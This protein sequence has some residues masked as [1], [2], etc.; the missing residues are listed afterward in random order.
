MRTQLRSRKA[1]F[2]LPEVVVGSVISTIVLT[3]AL[4]LFI[5]CAGAWARGENL[6]DGENDTRQAVRV[7]SDELRQAMLVT[8]DAD[9]R[10]ITYRHPNK[11]V[12][13]NFSVPVVWDGVSRRIY[14]NGT[15]LILR[16]NGGIERV[17]ARNVLTVDPFM[18]STTTVQRKMRNTSQG[19]EV[20]P[21]YRI[22]TPSSAGLINEVIVQIVTGTKGGRVG[23]SLRTRKRERV[24]LRNVPELIK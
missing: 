16:G 5:A 7:I 24:V 6:M 14:L 15:N 17:V 9:G 23:E 11:D 8:I 4:S 3:S 21:S 20:A 13:G 12:N 19:V 2:T 1:G 18:L 10:G 22:F